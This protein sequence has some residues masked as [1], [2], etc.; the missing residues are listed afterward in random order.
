MDG[1]T[2]SDCS[3]VQVENIELNSALSLTAEFE[4]ILFLIGIS[5]NPSSKDPI[6]KNFKQKLEIATK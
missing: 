1:T 3:L 6:S 5:K 4:K 2:V